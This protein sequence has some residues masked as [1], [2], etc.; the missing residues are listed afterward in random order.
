MLGNLDLL[1]NS[2]D[3]GQ[4]ANLS[5]YTQMDSLYFDNSLYENELHYRLKKLIDDMP[6]G[7]DCEEIRIKADSEEEYN[8]ILDQ[9]FEVGDGTLR[10][11]GVSN[12]PLEIIIEKDPRD[13]YRKFDESMLE[14]TSSKPDFGKGE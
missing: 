12:K 3:V 13:K 8:H 14:D 4:T 6:I 1:E 9:L 5:P 2:S 7:E 10:A 11:Y